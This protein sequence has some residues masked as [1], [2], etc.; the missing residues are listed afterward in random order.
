MLKN[1]TV[2]L[3]VAST[4]AAFFAG[5]SSAEAATETKAPSAGVIKIDTAHPGAKIS[6]LLYGI[7]FEE[8][9]RAGEGGIYAEMIQNRSFEDN[10][11]FPIAWFSEKAEISLNRTSPIHADNPTSLKVVAQAGGRVMN[12]GFVGGPQ[13]GNPRAANR[14]WQSNAAAQPGQIFVEA[15]AEYDLTLYARSEKGGDRLDVSLVGSDGKVLA[16]SSITPTKEWRK[17]TILLTAQRT[18]KNAQLAIGSARAA[19][20]WLDMV[21]LFPRRTWKNRKNGLRPDLMKMVAAMKPAFVRFPGGC[22]VE[23]RGIENRAIWKN[24]IGPVE[25]R[26]G[27]WCIWQYQ[28]S[29]GLGYHEYL[30][31]CEDLGAEPLFVINC[32]MGHETR[33]GR[34]TMYEVPMNEMQPFVQDALDAIEY[35]NGPV[36]S[37]WGAERAKNGHSAP[38]NMKYIEIGN[39]NGGR[40][41]AERYALIAKAILEKYPNMRLVANE[42]TAGYKNDILDPHLYSDS[43]T[44][45][46]DATRFDN[47][48]RKGPEIYFGEYA[49][50]SGAG[51]GNLNAALGEAAFMTG[52]ER[53]GDIV[54]MSSYA[55]LFRRAG[56]ET[57]N[58]DAIVFD[59]SRVFGTPSYWTQVM[60]SNNR[61]DRNLDLTLTVSEEN[62]KTFRGFVGLGSW[63]TKV[64]YKDLRITQGDKVLAAP[65]FKTGLDGVM[66]VRG[67]WLALNGELMQSTL[68]TDTL[69]IIG[70]PEWEDYTISVK[71]KKLEGNEGFLIGF[72][73]PDAET[74]SWLNLGGWGNT[75]HGI[76][77]PDTTTHRVG[78]VI[79]TGKWYDIRIDV[80]KSNVVCS[81]DGK[82]IFD[83]KIQQN[84]ALAAV[85]GLDQKTGETILKFVNSNSEPI[86]L[87][88]DTGATKSDAI[89]GTV[90]TLAGSDQNMENTFEEPH[91]IVPKKKEFKAKSDDFRYTFPANSISILRWK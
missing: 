89:K 64:A 67:Q 66:P 2:S 69:A 19:T 38:F 24:S 82:V 20:Y 14:Q 77:H 86:T 43:N 33:N 30:Q 26:I 7:F 74:K 39:E 87:T 16:H 25:Q 12:R 73:M 51:K 4:A 90:V 35:A 13:G 72:A 47:Q 80:N 57:W 53:N 71:A 44:F 28:V 75:D 78:G 8:I 81:I 65:E 46:R 50:T 63:E 62:Q 45:R 61:A 41:Y 1:I 49:V 34:D 15:G 9:N 88:V 29:N 6:P 91:R 17:Y 84:S 37:K 52:L 18:D 48:D 55:P 60:F 59:Q 3:L 27:Q 23:G 36:T 56:W 11:S 42:A 40:A 76:E 5:C 21:S 10:V 85:A 58:P 83:Q 79:E 32:G 70:E 68:D 22:F 54:I 31:M